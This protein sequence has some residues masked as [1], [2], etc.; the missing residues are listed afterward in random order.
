MEVVDGG[1]ETMFDTQLFSLGAVEN[2][3]L[4]NY[5]EDSY[6]P[7]IPSGCDEAI[8]WHLNE[9]LR[10]DR[11]ESFLYTLYSQSTTRVARQTLTVFEHR[12]VGKDRT[13]ELT[14]SAA[15]QWG[16][17][18]LGMLGRVVG[19]ELWL[20]QATPRR[21][22]N[23][24]ERVEVANLQT[25]FGPVA[26]SVHSRLKSGSIEARVTAPHRRSAKRIRMR[27]RVPDERRMQSV[28]V[29]GKE[30][31]DFDTDGEWVTIPGSNKESTILVRF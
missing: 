19:N 5:F 7:M 11:V 26:F 10:Q 31:R 27:F 22:L 8:N 14:G 30:W 28:T 16:S 21:W 9:Y 15:C 4:L 17:N 20:M 23:D 13:F 2:D 1:W 29:N 18:F 12:S 25:E 6:S 3:W 24:G